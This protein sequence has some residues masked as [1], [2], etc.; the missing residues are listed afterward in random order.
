MPIERAPAPEVISFGPFKLYPAE[1][2]LTNDNEPV[3]IGARAFDVLLVL[4]ERAGDVVSQRELME[5]VWPHV[6]VEEVSL[7]VHITA[8]RKVLDAGL[9]EARHV[10]NIP[11]RGY[12]FIVPVTREH[13]APRVTAPTSFAPVYRLPTAV[14]MVDREDAVFKVTTALKEER[15]VTIV[16]PGGMGKTTV[17][18]AVAHALLNDFKGRVCFVELCPLEDA[19]L[20]AA[21]VASAFGVPVQNDNPVPQ[22][23][24]HL[25]AQQTLL[26]LDCAEHL[27][28]ESAALVEQLL[29]ASPGLRILA[30]SREALRAANENVHRL[31]PLDSPPQNAKLSAAEVLAFPAVQ[32]FVQR[33][34]R[35]GRRIEVS[36]DDAPVIGRLCRRLDGIALA[37]ELAAGRV[38]TLG[39][40]DIAQRIDSQFA[41]R[42]PGRRTAPQR[43]QTL[44]AALD[45]S[46]DLLSEIERKI[47]RRLSIFSGNFTL[48]AAG[49][50]AG[51]DRLD[52]ELMHEAISGLFDKSLASADITGPVTQYSLLDTTRTYAAARLAEAKETEI[53]SRRHAAFHRDILKAAYGTSDKPA[54]NIEN[55]RAAMQW[56][57]SVNGDR[58]LAIDLAAW[59]APVWLGQAMLAECLSWMAKAQALIG[60]DDNPT[61]QL[62]SIQHAVASAELFSSGLSE[63]GAALWAR[64]RDLAEQLGNIPLLF[65]AHLVI[66]AR[67]IRE[68]FYAD[69]LATG[70]ACMASAKRVGDQSHNA[71]AEWMVGHTKHH[72]GHQNEAQTH[73]ERALS[74]DTE[75]ARF[76]MIKS[77]GYDRRVD[78]MTILANTMWNRGFAEQAKQLAADAVIEA[79]TLELALPL[80]VALTW[81]GLTRYLSDPDNDA[82]EDIL[83]ELVEHGRTNSTL[84]EVGFGTCYLGLC[85]AR[86]GL[87]DQAWDLVIDGV[88]RMNEARMLTFNALAL[89]HLCEASIGTTKAEAVNSLMERIDREG[90]NPED[91][92]TPEIDR[93][94]GV[95]AL[96]N[97]D[98]ARALAHFQQS[99]SMANRH[100][101]LAWELKTR[102]SLAAFHARQNRAS[103][104]ANLLAPTYERFTEGFETIDLIAARTLLAELRSSRRAD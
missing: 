90:R 13:G 12:T 50:V 79:R 38:E 76:E 15:F 52:H 19:T 86:R 42:W 97:G 89:A 94:K 82:V 78:G 5:R 26:V 30:T 99:I 98:E 58:E 41:L 18:L 83:V 102:T 87:V 28:S 25:G 55:I 88:A 65:Q 70:L 100:G 9:D 23:I 39:V 16:G 54:A 1:R 32:L 17:A 103:D 72:I 101:S 96:S 2:L 56:A 37:I 31:A 71:M 69:A 53:V 27:V 104:A 74:L 35:G 11:G 48:E 45:W 51:L 6:N 67:E 47:L 3:K 64:T 20:L 14:Q 36:D 68:T 4:V 77:F 95:V 59:S 93:V 85:Q 43:H 46:H 63:Q 22:I 44:N 60:A 73:F 33:A 7:R 92:C 8:L 57:F 75:A 62:L 24:T 10:A 84:S 29:S 40:L 66:F 81:E 91:W 49:A 34:A 21:T 80:G 61:P